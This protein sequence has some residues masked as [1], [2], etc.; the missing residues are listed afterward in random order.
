VR[1]QALANGAYRV[2][3]DVSPN[4]A[5]VPNTYQVAVTKGGKPVTGADVKIRFTM[6]DMDMAQQVYQ[7][8]EKTPG[9]GVYAHDAPAFVMVGRWGVDVNV[10]PRDGQPFDVTVLDHAGG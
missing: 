6:L 7:L 4:R 2:A 3:L 10:A 5:A 1:R 8:A 9:S